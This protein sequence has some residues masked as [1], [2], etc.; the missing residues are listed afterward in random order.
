MSRVPPE[1]LQRKRIGEIP[2]LQS[3]AQRLGFPQLLMRY[4]K[5]HGNE[6]IA[7]ADT[8]LLLVFNIASGR[9]PLYELA[10]WTAQLDGR[11]LG[12]DSQ[13]PAALFNDDR[14]GR[15]LDKLFAVDRASLMT[16]V[17]LQ[18]I[19]ATDLNLQQIHN[20]ST[21]VKTTG[22]MPGKSRTGLF[23]A[24]GHSKDH[25]PDLKQIVF[26][27]TLSADGAVPIHYTTYPGNRT[28]DTTHIDTW[29]V[30][31]DIAGKPDFLYVADCKVC[32]AK[33][34]SFMVR[35]GGRVVTLLPATWKEVKT[36]KASLRAHQKAKQRILRR[37]IPNA[38]HAYETFYC[39]T[40]RYR[41]HQAGYALHWIYSTEKRKRDRLQRAQLLQR[42]EQELGQLMGKLNTRKLKTEA[43]ISARVDQILHNSQASDF[44]HIAIQPVQERCTRQVGRGRPGKHT[45]YHTTVRTI[46]ALSWTRNQPALAREKNIDGIF[47][48]LC[49]DATMSAKEALVAYKYQPRLEK[50][51]QQLK[52]VHQAA[53]TL[54]KKVERVEAMMFLFFLALIIQ[55]VIEREVRQS[56]S[57][58]AIDAIPIYPE[59]RLAYHPTTAKIFDR[60]HD[61][62][63]YR[64]HQGQVLVKEY[65]DELTP[66]QQSVLALLGMTEDD[67][68]R[69]L[70]Q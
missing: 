6:K 19:A 45:R 67:Y 43:Q 69:R 55:A 68:W 33:Q 60:F 57:D 64:V 37:P 49:T 29:R 36:F 34:L 9:Q 26:N 40:G 30:I 31:R 12:R 35:H 14:Y 42:V 23:F 24:R 10:H 61:T 20:D 46:Y 44:Y 3:I 41:T 70:T 48:I 65:R 66:V 1:K 25:R 27:L 8:L 22:K 56:M 63:L 28:D 32:T 18:V 16:D 47:P 2:L 50:R 11:L 59:H 15:A 38:E 39:F 52:S 13:L 4:I 5:P 7:A 54:F 62:S 51:F 21:S 58:N 53:P 17:V